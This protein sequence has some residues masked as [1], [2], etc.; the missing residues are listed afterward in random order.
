MGNRLGLSLEE[1]LLVCA[2]PGVWDSIEL[3][4]RALVAHQYDQQQ[5]AIGP[6]LTAA[7]PHEHRFVHVGLAKRQDHTSGLLL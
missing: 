4:L 7:V 2:K 1:Q 6:V 5:D 3:F